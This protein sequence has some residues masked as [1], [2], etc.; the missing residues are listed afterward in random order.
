LRS[1]GA[2]SAVSVTQPERDGETY[3]K[4]PTGMRIGSANECNVGCKHIEMKER[5]RKSAAGMPVVVPHDA[6]V[7]V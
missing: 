4:R 7:L 2:G 6:V 1:G 3:G 5:I